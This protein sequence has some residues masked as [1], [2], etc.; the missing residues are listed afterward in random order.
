[1][2]YTLV[3]QV[4]DG[5]DQS[6]SDE[7]EHPDENT[8]HND[9]GNDDQSVLSYLLGGRPDNL[10]QLA[11]E[12]A[13][14]SGNTLEQIFLFNFSHCPFSLLGLVVN[15]VLLAESAVL[16]HFETVRVILLVFHGIVVS[17]LALRTSQSDFNAHIG[18]SL[19]NCLPA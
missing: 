7:V 9:T 1:M 16:L 5:G 19:N 3:S 13:E 2:A 11:L 4:D 18:T 14:V 10:L 8:N 15:R 17:L 6:L 12:L